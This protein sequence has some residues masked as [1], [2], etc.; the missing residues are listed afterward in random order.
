MD[1]EITAIRVY[2]T[3]LGHGFVNVFSGPLRLK[4]MGT[5]N[6]KMGEKVV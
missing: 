1:A 4:W 3:Q 6:G 2:L 5:F